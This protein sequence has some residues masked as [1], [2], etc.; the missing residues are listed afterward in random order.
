MPVAEQPD[1]SDG[2]MFGEIA[3]GTLVGAIKFTPAVNDY[4]NQQVQPGVYTLRYLLLPVDGNHQGK[5]PGRDFVVLVPAALDTS[6][7]AI[8][9]KDLLDLS[10]KASS[11]DHAAVLSL[12]APP[13]N[14]VLRAL[15]SLVHSDQGDLWVMYF[16]APFA[17]AAAMG[18]VV[19]GHGP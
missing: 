16:A 12:V 10:R 18:I 13:S 4:H 11:T 6:S 1:R 8:A 15:P 9:P 5:A 19:A 2:V 14:P 7:D 3:Q 17:A